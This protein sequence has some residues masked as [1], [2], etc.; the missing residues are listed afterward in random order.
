M[1]RSRVAFPVGA[2]YIGETHSFAK[3]SAFSRTASC[4]PPARIN[5]SSKIPFGSKS[6]LAIVVVRENP[7]RFPS[8]QTSVPLS[9][10]F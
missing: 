8:T 3:P 7:M 5:R 2:S 6:A 1:S 9:S 10:S 4:F